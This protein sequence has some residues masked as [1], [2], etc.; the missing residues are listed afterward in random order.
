ML[1]VSERLRRA[2]VSGNLPITQRLLSRFPELWLNVD[3]TNKGWCNLHYASYYGNY[4]VCFHLISFF[5]NKIDG[6]SY[7][8]Y[9]STID[10]ITFDEL[11]VVHLPLIHHHAQT[12]H[13][14]LQ[15]FP[16]KLWLD[17]KGGPLKQTPLHYSCAHNFKEGMKLLLEF[18]AD[19]KLQ[20]LNG[21]TCLHI[22]FQY[23]FYECIET[24]LS[25]I[26]GKRDPDLLYSNVNNSYHEN[27]SNNDQSK[28][29][30]ISTFQ[31]FESIK[32][33]RGCTAIDYSY[34]FELV[35]KYKHLKANLISN[36]SNV[37]NHSANSLP[38][39]IPAL[40]HELSNGTSSS[41]S[42]SLLRFTQ[43]NHSQSSITEN[44][45]L[46]SPIIPMLQTQQEP[47]TGRSLSLSHQH[48]LQQ[49]S[50]RSPITPITLT[51]GNPNSTN[52]NTVKIESGIGSNDNTTN[53]ENRQVSNNRSHS[54]SLPANSTIPENINNNNNQIFTNKSNLILTNRSDDNLNSNNDINSNNNNSISVRKRAN[55]A[56]NFKPPPSALTF[57][58]NHSSGSSQKNFSSP[59]TPISSH[60]SVM[61]ATPSLKSVT[62]SPLTRN[63]RGD[64]DDI[65]GNLNRQ[66][67]ASPQS[68]ISVNSSITASPANRKRSTSS[69]ASH[70]LF[71]MSPNF[72][73]F[74]ESNHWPILE[75]TREK[76]NE[77]HFSI[78]IDNFDDINPPPRRQSLANNSL[79]GSPVL[80]PP[81]TTVR[82]P[83]SMSHKHSS[84]SPPITEARTRRSS[85]S[86]LINKLAFDSQHNRSSPGVDQYALTASRR[87]SLAKIST[88][89]RRFSNSSSTASLGGGH[90]SPI[91]RKSKSTSTVIH[92]P[93]SPAVSRSSSKSSLSISTESPL[94]EETTPSQLRRSISSSSNLSS[95]STIRNTTEDTLTAIP[96]TQPDTLYDHNQDHNQDKQTN[97]PPPSM[98]SSISF[99]RVR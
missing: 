62:I 36:L 75:I 58:S 24:L 71:N 65:L 55:T 45:V 52:L 39:S 66:T 38:P 89:S 90:E 2:I 86:S 96:T 69:S 46:S 6:N 19:W 84:A 11:T 47:G 73:S 1:E 98:A 35:D 29:E 81:I 54:Q 31:K 22:C 9:N 41:S 50:I 94:K 82:T 42:S 28:N 78:P 77:K 40:P 63:L 83:D 3:P 49:Q 80:Q 93:P 23:G 95:T 87:P 13:Y 60:P 16:G 33:E 20:D 85:S 10:M 7:E 70:H 5:N 56:H 4:L 34:S 59:Q 68:A 51:S 76:A 37:L 72:H 91:L 30:I 26:L 32:N 88:I 57:T 92:H 79:A 43:N 21:D 64:D 53:G 61:T 17:Y 97:Q 8:K 44:R 48:S 25:F 15:E 99:N 14:I 27:I 74:N 12:L 67:T 18:G